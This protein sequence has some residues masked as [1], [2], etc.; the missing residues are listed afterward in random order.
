MTNPLQTLRSNSAGV[1]SRW[2][3]GPTRTSFVEASRKAELFPVILPCVMVNDETLAGPLFHQLS[4]GRP[5]H[6]MLFHILDKTTQINA[7]AHNTYAA[8]AAMLFAIIFSTETIFTLR[9]HINS[10][11]WLLLSWPSKLRLV[12][13]S[14]TN[15]GFGSPQDALTMVSHLI[16]LP[17]EPLPFLT[18]TNPSKNSTALLAT[19]ISLNLSGK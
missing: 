17:L 14:V 15:I 19:L 4:L 6:L 10:A 7:Q 16:S 8:N 9:K 1:R 2:A 12:D 11:L 3:G 5:S 18:F 13:L